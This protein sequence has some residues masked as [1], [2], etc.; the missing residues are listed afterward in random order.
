MSAK[1]ETKVK[2]N[3]VKLDKQ[4]SGLSALAGKYVVFNGA[5]KFIGET[6]SSAMTMGNRKFGA[7]SGFVVRK[8]GSAPVLSHLVIK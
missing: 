8:I 6:F 5:E 1:L 3:A 7:E 4:M 2:E